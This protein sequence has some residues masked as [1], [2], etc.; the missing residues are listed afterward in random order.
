MVGEARLFD[1]MTKGNLEVDNN[2]IADNLIVKDG[3]SKYMRL[4][5]DSAPILKGKVLA[6]GTTLARAAPT[7]AAGDENLAMWPE[8]TLEY[9]VLGTQTLLGPRLVTAGL[10]VTQDITNNDGI[11]YCGGIVASNKL[12]FTVGTHAA[13]YA[14]LRCTITDVLGLD[15]V[16]FGWRKMEAYVADFNNIDEM[17]AFDIQEGVI[18]NSTAINGAAVVDV[19]TTLADWVTTTM[20]TME[21]RVSAAGVVTFLFDGGT[22]TAVSTF[23]FDDGEVVT[24]FFQFLHDATGTGT[25]TLQQFDCGLLTDRR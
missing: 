16:L 20:H 22:P 3:P 12:V 5:F 11:E 1:S 10:D 13:F 18:Y 2:I 7:G 19:D 24:P 4:D 17:A 21:V 25:I 9:H 23:T 15:T 14:R 6:N 8:G